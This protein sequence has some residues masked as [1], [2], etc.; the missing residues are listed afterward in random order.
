MKIKNANLTWNVL[1]ANDFDKK[2][3][4]SYNIL[5]HSFAEE[6]A[7]EIKRKKISNRDQLKEHLK[8]E[9]MYHYWSKSEFEIAVGGLFTK[10]EDLEKLDVWYQI[11][12]NFDNIIDYI[13]WKMDLFKKKE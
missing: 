2:T 4:R 5:G 11:E 13:I 6:L 7:K 10:Y 8:R 12:M 9:F 1:V 3:V